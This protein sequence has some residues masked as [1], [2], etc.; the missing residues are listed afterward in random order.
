VLESAQAINAAGQIVGYGRINGQEHAFLLTPWATPGPA[1][2]AADRP[3]AHAGAA[4]RGLLAPPLPMSALTV[5]GAG[6]APAAA[7][8]ADAH[9]AAGGLPA[10]VTALPQ[11]AGA[12]GPRPPARTAAAGHTPPTAALDLAFVAPACAVAP[13]LAAGRI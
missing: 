13:P 8:A 5:P 11:R 7:A 9:W 12:E 1:L 3:T 4:G 2:P 10:T 6:A